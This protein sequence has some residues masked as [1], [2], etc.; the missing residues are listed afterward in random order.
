MTAEEVQTKVPQRILTHSTL[1]PQ[2]RTQRAAHSTLLQTTSF[3][4]KKFWVEEGVRGNHTTTFSCNNAREDFLFSNADA[5]PKTRLH[6]KKAMPIFALAPCSPSLNVD[7]QTETVPAPQRSKNAKDRDEHNYTEHY[8]SASTIDC[9]GLASLLPTPQ[10][11]HLPP[12]DTIRLPGRNKTA[13][14]TKKT[15]GKAV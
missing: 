9:L 15:R 12:T 8:R 1:M 5:I 3:G 10:A 13:T 2:T 14:A 11:R 6:T 7:F 4:D